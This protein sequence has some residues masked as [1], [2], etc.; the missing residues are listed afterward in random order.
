HLLFAEHFLG[1]RRPGLV[2]EGVL[3]LGTALAAIVLFW[4]DVVRLLKAG[5][6]LVTRRGSAD[7]ADPYAKLALAIVVATAVTAALG[8]IFERPLERMFLSVRGVAFQLIITGVLLLWHHERGQRPAT[9]ATVADGLALGLAQAVAIIPGISRS[10]TTIVTGLRLGMQ[11][12][13][14]TRLSFL[15]AIPAIVGAG[16]LTLKD[17][18]QATAMGYTVPQLA[19][20]FAVAAV[21]GAASIRWLMDMVRRGRLMYFAVYCWIVGALV[22]VV[23]R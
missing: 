18:R 17:A 7:A 1:I 22:L 11:R 3:H 6:R 2:L 20:G 4:P 12:A 10:G 21:V 16:L 13:E 23:V 5:L 15:I 9:D 19:V 14:A 8:L